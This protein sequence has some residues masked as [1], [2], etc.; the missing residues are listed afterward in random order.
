MPVKLVDYVRWKRDLLQLRM[1][2]TD[3]GIIN[4]T[5]RVPYAKR[6]TARLHKEF[7]RIQFPFKVS[8]HNVLVMTG[9]DNA[10]EVKSDVKDLTCMSIIQLDQHSFISSILDTA[11]ILHVLDIPDPDGL[12]VARANQSSTQWIICQGPYQRIM[13]FQCAETFSCPRRPHLDFTVI[14]TRDDKAVL[15]PKL[16]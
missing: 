8:D 2:G 11:A 7:C 1:R 4:T 13:A 12:V 5:T 10:T 3:I 15:Q 16:I 9:A 6:K 14:G